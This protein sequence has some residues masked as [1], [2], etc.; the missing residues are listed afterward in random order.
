LYVILDLTE[1]QQSQINALLLDKSQDGPII[2]QCYPDGIICRK[3]SIKMAKQ[4]QADT[5]HIASNTHKT[6][7]ERMAE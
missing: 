6:L 4:I 1:T 2:A 3:I 7:K 5:G